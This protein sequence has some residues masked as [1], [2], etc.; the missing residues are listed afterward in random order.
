M[1]EI[2]ENEVYTV[3]ET[4]DLLKVSQ[5][6]VMRM[7]KKGILKAGRFGGQYRIL[8]RELLRHVLPENAYH[9]V[10]DKYQKTKQRIKSWEENE[11]DKL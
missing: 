7:I 8:G 4:Q 2:K 9:K 10:A 6:T 1:P 11:N 5:S 3:K